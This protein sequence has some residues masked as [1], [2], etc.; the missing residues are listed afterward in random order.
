M[1]VTKNTKNVNTDFY[2]LQYYRNDNYRSITQNLSDDDMRY[3]IV[4]FIY[5]NEVKMKSLATT[6]TIANVCKR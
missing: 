1:W 2:Y 5:S 4:P 3:F 6:S